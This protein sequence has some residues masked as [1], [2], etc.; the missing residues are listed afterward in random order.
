MG[1][2]ASDGE[3]GLK[4]L[5]ACGFSTREVGRRGI[6]HGEV[7]YNL[8]F[9]ETAKDL[10]NQ[11]PSWDGPVSGRVTGLSF[12]PS[13]LGTVGETIEVT[14]TVESHPAD[15]A[16]IQLA[17]NDATDGET[18]GEWTILG[19][20]PLSTNSDRATFLWDTHRMAPGEHRLAINVGVAG[21]EVLW[22]YEQ[23]AT[24]TYSLR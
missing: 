19:T 8:F 11:L 9:Y 21:G 10:R 5:E 4:A 20:Q 24:P 7:T 22:W 16:W 3:A 12:E 17:V 14:L 1:P 15:P 6:D 13:I 2:Q 18:R 23:S